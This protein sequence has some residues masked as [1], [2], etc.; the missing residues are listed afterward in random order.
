M[1]RPH[2]SIYIHKVGLIQQ[3]YSVLL[4]YRIFMDTHTHWKSQA[5][6]IYVCWWGVGCSQ[7]CRPR[8]SVLQPPGLGIVYC[9]RVV[10]NNTNPFIKHGRS[11]SSKSIEPL[12][13]FFFS[14]LLTTFS[15][16][17][18]ANPFLYILMGGGLFTELS[19]PPLSAPA[20][21]SGHR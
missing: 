2:H 21:W 12:R 3:P 7:S 17:I 4:W 9:H 13:S 10:A 11:I 5:N 8:P 16:L 15:A 19:P 18:H 1:Y 20:A 6:F 14:R